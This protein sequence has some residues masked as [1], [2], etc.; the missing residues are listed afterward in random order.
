MKHWPKFP[1]KHTA[2]TRDRQV[3]ISTQ[4][5]AAG[6]TIH[7]T[8]VIL[9]TPV[10]SVRGRIHHPLAAKQA[11]PITTGCATFPAHGS[12]ATHVHSSP[13]RVADLP[14]VPCRISV[15]N[16][17]VTF[18]FPTV[19]SSGTPLV[20]EMIDA[21][22]TSLRNTLFERASRAWIRQLRQRGVLPRRAA[23]AL[24]PPSSEPLVPGLLVP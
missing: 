9:V 1:R 15:R 6:F 13:N 7:R 18:Q 22:A 19:N 3:S 21:V 10:P 16:S 2:S 20:P 23:C 11:F 17:F 4:P 24:P 14:K 8:H 5:I 12:N